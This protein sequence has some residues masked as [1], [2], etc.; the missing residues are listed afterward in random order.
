MLSGANFNL[1]EICFEVLISFWFEK[2]LSDAG[3]TRC[4]K[5]DA[6]L[7]VRKYDEY[8]RMHGRH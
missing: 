2:Y 1:E 8:T 4:I 7:R 5:Y 6:L 3:E